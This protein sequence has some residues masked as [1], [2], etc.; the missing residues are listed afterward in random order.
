MTFDEALRAAIAYRRSKMTWAE[1]AKRVGHD[2]DK[3]RESA[4]RQGRADGWGDSPII[5]DAPASNHGMAHY[6]RRR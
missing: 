6:M 4:L 2:K 3:L 1:I 5:R